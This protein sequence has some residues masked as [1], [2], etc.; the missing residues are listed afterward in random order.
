IAQRLRAARAGRTTVLVA[1]SPLLLGQ[2]DEVAFLRGG[3][4]AATG[5]HADLLARDPA[6]RALVARDADAE[7]AG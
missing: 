4:V 3:R 6:Y 5:R 7:V 1:T 2:A